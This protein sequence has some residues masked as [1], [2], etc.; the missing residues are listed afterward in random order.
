M[1]A[2]M[3]LATFSQPVLL[4]CSRPPLSESKNPIP[5]PHQVSTPCRLVEAHPEGPHHLLT[6]QEH[7]MLLTDHC[8]GQVLGDRGWRNR[9]LP[10]HAWVVV[11][12]CGARVG[13]LDEP[14]RGAQHPLLP[15][16]ISERGAKC[17]GV[18]H[19]WGLCTVA[20]RP[21]GADPNG[22]LHLGHPCDTVRQHSSEVVVLV[23]SG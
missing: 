21:G 15:S 13:S 7:L 12:G 5:C 11:V 17:D 9:Y 2:H 23:G 3:A 22:Y 4:V 14:R 19:P 1:M 18:A 8:R 20:Q 6:P 10:T 16:A